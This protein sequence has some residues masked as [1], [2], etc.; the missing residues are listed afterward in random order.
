MKPEEKDEKLMFERYDKDVA[1]VII[2][3]GLVDMMIRNKG[4]EE[5]SVKMPNPGVRKH[6]IFGRRDTMDCEK[7]WEEKKIDLHAD[8]YVGICIDIDPTGNHK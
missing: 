8:G 4:K 3:F 5:I 2:R 7:E 6:F 1:E